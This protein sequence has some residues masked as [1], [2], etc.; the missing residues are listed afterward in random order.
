MSPL[1]WGFGRQNVKYRQTD[2]FEVLEQKNLIFGAPSQNIN[3]RNNRVTAQSVA[4]RV[5]RVLR[6]KNTEES[7]GTSSFDRG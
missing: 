5:L 4:D 2:S 6:S 1:G 3:K 7:T